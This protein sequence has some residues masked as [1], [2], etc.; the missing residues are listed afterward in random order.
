M[1]VQA[2][3]ATANIP[4]SVPAPSTPAPASG[5]PVIAAAPV[6][7]TSLVPAGAGGS[8]AAT[9]SSTTTGASSNAHPGLATLPAGPPDGSKKGSDADATLTSGIAR[10]YN[11]PQQDVSVSFQ[12]STNPNEI[13]TVFTDTKT[14]KVIV[15]FPSE[16]MIA[17]AKLFDKLDGSVVNKKV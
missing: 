9:A 5:A 6:A 10:L 13:V 17:L 12:I 15:Q 7:A 14:G 16:T 1:D 2:A 4:P 8:N 11:I 3:A